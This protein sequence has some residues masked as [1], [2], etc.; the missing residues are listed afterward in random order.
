MQEVWKDIPGYEGIY[1]VSNMG[2]V[3]SVKFGP[4]SVAVPLRQTPKIMSASR[5]SSG[6]FHVQLYKGGKSSTKLIHRLVAEAFIPNPDNLPQIN[7]RDGNKANNRFDNLEWVTVSENQK[8]AI[9][10]GLREP[11]P[12]IG[13]TGA[14]SS[15]S[16]PVLQY[17]LNGNLIKRWDCGA[18]AARFYKYGRHRTCR[19]F[20]WKRA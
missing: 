2:R 10:L 8:H 16:I 17:D 20:I 18:D 14:L 1:Q 7:H 3:L 4:K 15:A 5:S 19:G 13:K 9:K 6:Y 12:T 11:S